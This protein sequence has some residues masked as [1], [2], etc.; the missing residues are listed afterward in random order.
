MMPGDKVMLVTDNHRLSGALA[1]IETI[2]EWG[3]HVLTD[4]AATGRYRALFTE[5]VPIHQANG[6]AKGKA[7]ETA[8][9]EMCMRCG[10]LRMQRAGACLVCL[11]CGES[12]GCG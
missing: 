6:H 3:A 10:S 11:D 2:T 4:Q 5:M 8:T 9:G 12:G 7:P 1:T